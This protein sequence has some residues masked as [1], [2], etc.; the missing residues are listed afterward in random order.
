M[1]FIGNYTVP[2][3]LCDRL[4]DFFEQ[5]IRYHEPGVVSN[6]SGDHVVPKEKIST[7]MHFGGIDDEIVN[8]YHYHLQLAL[9][10]YIKEYP[11]VNG[12]VRFLPS[13]F[14]IQK[15]EKNEGYFK[16][17]SE[18]NVSNYNRCLVYMTYLNDVNDS[19][20]TEFKYQEVKVK[21]K[22]GRTLIWPADWTHTHRG[23][24]SKTETKYILTGWYLSQ[25]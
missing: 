23:I 14:R 2:E 13:V 19:G 7:D 21:P 22:K 3:E 10:E 17:H 1:N 6:S 18:R 20:E 9:N 8:E 16:W 25:F 11:E 15:Y 12:I 5:N 4:I 24:T